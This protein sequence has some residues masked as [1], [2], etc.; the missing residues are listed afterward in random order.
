M[1][2][3][4]VLL[5]LCLQVGVSGLILKGIPEEDVG[6]ETGIV[7]GP[8]D[9]QILAHQCKNLADPGFEPVKICMDGWEELMQKSKGKS[10]IAYDIGVRD[11]ADFAATMI[12]QFGCTVRA[13]DPS[14][15]TKLWWDEAK[16]PDGSIRAPDQKIGLLKLKEHEKAGKYTLKEEAAGGYDG[17][18][19]LFAYNWQQISTFRATPDTQKLQKEFIV[20]SKTLAKMMEDHGDSHIDV[21]KVD[22]EGSEFPFLIAVFDKGNCPP[23]EHLLIEWHSQNMDKA[24]GAPPEV[25]ELE[26]KMQKCGYKMYSNYPFFS[27]HVTPEENFDIPITYYGHAAYCKS[28]V[29]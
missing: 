27:N 23:V 14:P 1:S 18:L 8:W 16:N 7:S 4:L 13:Y 20:P 24:F 22:I 11:I 17:D 29:Q 5:S 28:C 6:K 10:C 3:T 9:Q 2:R 25:K 12:E 19:K 26:S 15:T 21:L